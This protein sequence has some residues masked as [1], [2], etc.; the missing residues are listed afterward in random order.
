MSSKPRK[1]F[2]LFPWHILALVLLL[3]GAGL[4]NLYSASSAATGG[5]SA[6]FHSQLLWA[7]IGLVL[8]LLMLS[9]HY[10]LLLDVAWPLYFVS[11]ALLV[12]VILFG[13]VS[14]GQKNWLA[15]GPLRLQ[16]SEFAKLAVILMLA[17][18]F[19]RLPPGGRR[20]LRDFLP[21]LL[22]VAAPMLLILVEKD[23]GSALFFALIG[24]TFL[25]LAGLPYRF[26]VVALLLACLGGAAGYRY[27]LSDYQRDRIQTFLHPERDPRG[28]GYHLMQSKIAVGSGRALGKGF[29]KGD[30]NKFKF[31]P[32]R[33]TDFVFPVLAE[34]WG[35]AGSVFVLGCFLLLFLL[36]LHA[37]G[38][39]QDR[40]GGLLVVGVASL[41][42][43]QMAINLGG[44]LGLMPLAGVT[45]PFF[46]YGGSA[47]LCTMLGMGVA[48]NALMRRYM[49]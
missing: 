14:G 48:C 27:F 16:P 22:I 47:L 38:K 41:L 24:A 32:E 33:H 36:M 39:M 28:K 9:F 6:Y 12:G 35:F 34:E 2:Y 15:L 1:L 18:Y 26:I 10:R 3:L 11:L 19:H 29:L 49:F 23:L 5:L 8:M 45:L 25:F 37:A 30:L 31:L 42:F 17:R 44:V 7:G 20:T 13:K 43:W 21:P 40:F 46:S 4:V